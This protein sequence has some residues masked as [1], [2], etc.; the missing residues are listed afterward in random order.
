[1]A[2]K[3]SN[4]KHRHW[5]SSRRHKK[6]APKINTKGRR[7]SHITVIV[8]PNEHPERAIKRFLKKCKKLKIV[9]EFRKRQYYEKPSV[10]RRREKLRRKRVIEKALEK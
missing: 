9:E 5:D 10:K 8:R 4:K 2:Y 1:M 3:R 6:Q 7:P